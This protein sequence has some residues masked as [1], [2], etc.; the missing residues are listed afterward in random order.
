MRVQL[1]KKGQICV[2]FF[3]INNMFYFG[4]V[5]LNLINCASFN[6]IDFF[7]SVTYGSR[8]HT[9]LIANNIYRND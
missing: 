9:K 1:K 8:P 4:W 7:I 2:I 6:M 5:K 3:F